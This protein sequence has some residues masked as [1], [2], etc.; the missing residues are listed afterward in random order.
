VTDDRWAKASE[1]YLLGKTEEE[2]RRGALEYAY[3]MAAPKLPMHLTT[4]ECWLMVPVFVV[5]LLGAG[6]IFARDM[7]RLPDDSPGATVISFVVFGIAVFAVVLVRQIILN[8]RGY[9]QYRYHRTGKDTF[10]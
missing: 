5:A 2:R 1:A 3:L 9:R 4:R 8:N 6:A 7:A 10:W